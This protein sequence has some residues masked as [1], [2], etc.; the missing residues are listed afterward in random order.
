MKMQLFKTLWRVFG[1]W[2]LSAMLVCV[3]SIP[4]PVSAQSGGV[5]Y[6]PLIS[7]PEGCSTT[8]SAQFGLIN[9]DGGYYKGNRLTDENAD[10]RLSVLGFVETNAPLGFVTYDGPFDPSDALRFDGIFEPNRI[11]AFTKA[12]KRR[13]WNWNES[14]PPPYGTPGGANNDWPVSTL[15]FG[16][17]RGEGV[18]PAERAR[19]IGGGFNAMV[20]YAGPEEITL[21]YYRQDGVS[22]GFVV[23]LSGF[24]VDPNLIALYRAQTAGGRRS[25]GL[26]PGVRNNQRLGTVKNDF[27]T[28]AIRDRGTFLDP[29]SQRD[30][31]P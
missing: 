29:R 28:I 2:A 7:K 8:S 15:N 22:D 18:F 14:G 25:T 6:L 3:S 30:W 9:I 21:A 16:A 27:V 10:L 4:Q 23:Y 13:D 12:F 17:T 19:E 26:L 31:W 11:P 20:L 24:C 5:I 1:T